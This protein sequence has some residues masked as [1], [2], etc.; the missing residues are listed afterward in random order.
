M[1]LYLDTSA[2]AK[3]YIQ[4]DGRDLVIAAVAA[5]NRSV[6]STIAYPETRSALARKRREGALDTDQHRQAIDDLARDWQVFGRL[7]VT[8]PLAFLAGELTET[9]GLRGYDAV[10]LATAMAF[11]EEFDDLAFFSF[12]DR[13]NA[14]AVEAGLTLHVPDHEDAGSPMP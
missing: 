6:T 5:P 12:D 9:Y 1:T 14:A 13:L 8:E 7:D 3:L 10:H 2:L 4:E 11:A